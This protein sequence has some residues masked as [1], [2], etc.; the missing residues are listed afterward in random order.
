MHD[1]NVNVNIYHDQCKFKYLDFDQLHVVFDIGDDD[2]QLINI[3]V[4][5]DDIYTLR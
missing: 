4:Y 1:H 3:D 5:D 2:N